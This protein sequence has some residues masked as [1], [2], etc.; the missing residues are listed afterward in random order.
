MRWL[1]QVVGDQVW[2]SLS[3]FLANRY[4]QGEW[5]PPNKELIADVARFSEQIPGR[6]R[7]VEHDYLRQ[8]ASVPWGTTKMCDGMVVGGDAPAAPDLHSMGQLAY[9]SGRL[10]DAISRSR[11][12]DA[13]CCLSLEGIFA[14]HSL[15]KAETFLTP[16]ALSTSV[17]L[18]YPGADNGYQ[19]LIELT[20]VGAS[21]L[22]P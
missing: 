9:Q 2:H 6:E 5:N 12:T 16:E 8:L 3:D 7:T 13:A 15:H 19:R 11:V 21:L 14:K 18:P 17:I 10:S 22:E 20:S 4:W 1:D